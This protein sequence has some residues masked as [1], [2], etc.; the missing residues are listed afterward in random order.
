M[1]PNALAVLNRTY[2]SNSSREHRPVP[3]QRQHRFG[4]HTGATIL[5]AVP[6]FYAG[7]ATLEDAITTVVARAL[8][9]A[10]IDLGLARRWGSD[11]S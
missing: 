6:S 4:L 9:H 8:D 10:G 3:A 7:V 2:M 11:V 1:Q 5:P